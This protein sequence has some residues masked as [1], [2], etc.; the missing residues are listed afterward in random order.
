MLLCSLPCTIQ[1]TYVRCLLLTFNL[2]IPSRI[3]DTLIIMRLLKDK[4][5]H[6]IC[7]TFVSN[8]PFVNFKTF[9][10]NSIELSSKIS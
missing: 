10:F 5:K 4:Y 1:C 6:T 9:P 7:I 8:V 3:K 2:R